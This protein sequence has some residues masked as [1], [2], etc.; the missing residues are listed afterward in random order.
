MQSFDELVRICSQ[1]TTHDEACEWAKYLAQLEGCHVYS[2]ATQRDNEEGWHAARAKGIGGSDIAAIMGESTWKSP[3]DIWLS[4]TGQLPPAESNIQSEPARWGNL[5]ED[6][7]A[8]EWAKRNNKQIIKIPITLQSDKYSFML[9]NIDGFVLSDDGARV[10]GILEIKTTSLHNKAT[11]ET[12]PLPYYYICQATWY[13][14]ITNLPAFDIV[15]LVGGQ[16]MYSYHIPKDPELCERMTKAA[17]DFWT[18]NVGNLVEPKATAVDIARFQS[19]D[20]AT[21]AEEEPCVDES[22]STNNVL[23]AYVE[24]RDKISALE[25]I[26]A[27]LAAEIW[28]AL[29]H[30]TVMLTKSNV[31]KVTRTTRRSCDIDALQRDFPEAYDATVRHTVS[32]SL[33][34]R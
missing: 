11:W 34:I 15:C 18:V 1:A 3:Y 23:V 31:V 10:E 7:I 20:I 25:K 12:G 17:Y 8:Y 22:D 14:M 27:N 32:Q 24:L 16:Y 5:L 4:K 30:K 29:N 26:K 2:T 21:E 6:T 28:Q 33:S 9:A 19:A 13:T